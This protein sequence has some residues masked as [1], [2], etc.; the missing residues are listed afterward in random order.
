MTYEEKGIWVYLGVVLATYGAYAAIVLSRLG[1]APVAE[2]DYAA[3]LL[4]SIGASILSAIV[5]RVG[6]EIVRPSESH[7]ADPRDREIDR[8]GELVGRWPL[9]AGAV[10]ALALAL[11]QADYFWIANALYL[12]FVASAVLASVVKIL[13]YRRG[14]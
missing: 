14:L 9:I 12:G 8:A 1:T 5:L 2:V 4:W 13:S 10:V 7:D 6:L 11:A 3:P